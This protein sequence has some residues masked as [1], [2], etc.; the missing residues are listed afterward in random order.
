MASSNNGG[1]QRAHAEAPQRWPPGG[2]HVRPEGLS[3]PRVT[4]V[5]FLFVAAVAS[6]AA[7][8][9]R[10]RKVELHSPTSRL[11]GYHVNLPNT[12]SRL[13]EQGTLS[14]DDLHLIIE[15]ER[16]WFRERARV[17][18]QPLMSGRRRGDDA[19][20]VLD[21]LL[22]QGH[23]NGLSLRGKSLVWANLTRSTDKDQDLFGFQMCGADLS[24]LRQPGFK[25][26][27]RRDDGSIILRSFTDLRNA[28]LLGAELRSANLADSDLRGAILIGVDFSDANLSAV[29]LYAADLRWAV[30]SGSDL[31]NADLGQ[32]DLAGVTYEPKA[33]A[34]PKAASFISAK[35]VSQMR[36]EVSPAGLIELRE[37]FKTAG[38]DDQERAVTFALKRSE[39][40]HALNAGLVSRLEGLISLLLFDWTTAYGMRP[41]RALAIL[42]VLVPVFAPFYALALIFPRRSA[43]WAL[44]SQGAINGNAKTRP[45]RMVASRNDK[46][47]RFRRTL[48][49]ARIGL[50]FSLLQAFRV[51][52][53]EANI[54]EWIE[55]LQA[56]EYSLKATGWVRTVGGLQ[57]LIG[58]YLLA[59]WVLTLFGRPFG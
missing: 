21:L 50:Y 47:G 6:L 16:T 53:R 20:T 36:W 10:T 35:N 59:M 54:G 55:R 31:S 48:R 27:Y 13:V 24:G 56:R 45:L 18:T 23:G 40:A 51:G 49:A 41:W 17:E 8:G 1:L 22:K 46:A 58:V 3:T 44:R 25:G 19:D 42:L 33:G 37:A 2:T 26:A 32:S 29:D 4:Q 52:F 15:A 11:L 34:H 43:I 12:L 30:F 7:C 57:S 14:A 38:L 39:Q 5:V 28:N 9:D